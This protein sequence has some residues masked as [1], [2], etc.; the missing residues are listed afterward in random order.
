MDD[1]DF[2]GK[3]PAP[4]VPAAPAPADASRKSEPESLYDPRLALEFFRIAGT[5]EQF[6]AGKQIFV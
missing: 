2:S 3:P 5:L 4:V 1:L 6:A